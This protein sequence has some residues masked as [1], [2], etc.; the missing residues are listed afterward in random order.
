VIGVQ[1]REEHRLQAAEVKP[2]V[3][4][5]GRRPAAAVDDEDPP[6]DNERRRDP[7]P[8]GDRHGRSG[9]PEEHQFGC[10]PASLPA[11]RLSLAHQVS[12]VPTWSWP[13][14]TPHTRWSCR[15]ASKIRQLTDVSL[16]NLQQYLS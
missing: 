14:A 1:V 7:G 6:I 11:L 4:E 16:C 3:G 5:R 10:H 8:A 9:R 13:G 15:C 12:H 2:R